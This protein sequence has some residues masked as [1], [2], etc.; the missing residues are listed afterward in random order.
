MTERPPCLGRVGEGGCAALRLL[1]TI[2]HL[3]I[4][5]DTKEAAYVKQIA[6]FGVREQSICRANQEL[7]SELAVATDLAAQLVSEQ[8]AAKPQADQTDPN[9][10]DKGV[11]S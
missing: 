6:A 1:N 7:R 10:T 11:S 5:A 2:E 8:E 3:L 4:L 9:P